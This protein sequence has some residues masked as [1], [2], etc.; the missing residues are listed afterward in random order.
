MTIIQKRI[1]AVEKTFDL[2]VRRALI[3]ANAKRYQN[4]TKK[5]RTK[6]LDEHSD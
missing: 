4:S 1:C 5:E 6:I 2:M 3:R